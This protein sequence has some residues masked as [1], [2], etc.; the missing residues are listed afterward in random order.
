MAEPKLP[1]AVNQVDLTVVTRV[2]NGINPFTYAQGR[3]IV[4]FPLRAIETAQ[5][6][7]QSES[8]PN[9]ERLARIKGHL[10]WHEERLN[11][12]KGDGNAIYPHADDLKKWTGS[13]FAEWNVT[14]EGAHWKDAKVSFFKE[15]GET[16]LS[17]AESA[18]DAAGKAAG[19]VV[20][21]AGRAASS[22]AGGFFS[23]LSLGTIAVA[24]LAIG[25]GVLFLKKR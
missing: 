12:W 16:L 5:R 11:A 8:L 3:R 9:K 2:L 21:A 13:A 17:M 14:L 23:E 24:A 10:E 20:E 19:K 6:A 22:A 1:S 7:Q 4:T 15:Y 18:G 25:G